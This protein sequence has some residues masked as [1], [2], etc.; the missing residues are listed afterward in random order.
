MIRHATMDDM[1]SILA[2]GMDSL[3]SGPYAGRVAFNRDRCTQLATQLIKENGVVL[4]WQEPGYPAP[5]GILAF[6]VTPHFFTGE[7][8]AGEVMW[9]VCPEARNTGAALKLLWAAEDTA[10]A[11]GAKK[12][13]FTAPT[14]TVAA[15]YK[16][17]GYLQQEVLYQKEL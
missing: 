10:R 14:D 2:L 8:T 13:Q 9:Y 1:E 17:F 15:L 4:L 12:M 16:R 6:I 3:V 7:I 5:M 11:M